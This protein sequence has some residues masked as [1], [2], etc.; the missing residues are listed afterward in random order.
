[1]QSCNMTN[2][3]LFPLWQVDPQ[4]YN[5]ICAYL[6]ISP[7]PQLFDKLADY[8]LQAPFV[9]TRP[10][11]FALFLAKPGLSKFRIARLDML[12]KFLFR[13]HP[14][15]FILNAVIALHECDGKGY[16]ELSAAPVGWQVPFS[17]LRWGAGFVLSLAITMVWFFWNYMKYLIA[18]PFQAKNDLSGKRV[19]ITGV[20]RG[21]GLEI[22]LYSLQQGADVVGTVRNR[23]AY[24]ELIAQLPETAPVKLVIADLSQVNGITQ[25]L[26]ENQITSDSIDIAVLCAGIKHSDTSVLSLEKIRETFQV[27][28][29][30]SMELSKWLCCAEHKTSLV[31]ISS[32]GRWHGMHSS[33]GYNAAKSALSIWGESLEMELY[34]MGRKDCSI[35]IVEP[36]IFESGMMKKSASSQFL[37]ASRRKLAERII[38]GALAGKKTLRYPYWFALLT[39][40]ICL[41]GRNFQNY[42]FARA[43]KSIG[44]EQ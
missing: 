44:K 22:L 33:A 21:L 10:K 31:L 42:F 9:F 27:N 13:D 40:T 43:R 41:G 34:A 37:F 35:M 19:L 18:L 5:A 15:R 30:S 4:E 3:P 32:I 2:S 11:G 36:G 28:C 7:Q 26:Q 16:V 25:A 6:D 20:S 17:L 38:C 23:Q 24:A 14:V 1:M 12:S 39:W 29:F 8:L